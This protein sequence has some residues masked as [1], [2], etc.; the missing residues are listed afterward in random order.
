MRVIIHP[1]AQSC[2]C[3]FCTVPVACGGRMQYM[4]WYFER[5]SSCGPLYWHPWVCHSC[6]VVNPSLLLTRV[7]HRKHTI[8]YIHG[9]VC[10]YVL[11]SSILSLSFSLSLS[12]FSPPPPQVSMSR[13]DPDKYINYE[14]LAQNLKVI[15]D[16]YVYVSMSYIIPHLRSLVALARLYTTIHLFNVITTCVFHVHVCTLCKVPLH[17]LCI[18]CINTDTSHFQVATTF[19]LGRKDHLR[20]PGWP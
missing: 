19:D 20:S 3:H 8:K 12:L 2:M 4:Y 18:L 5:V 9:I 11:A 14:R 16:R 7:L 17:C 6:V 10:T 15:K 13:F 1:Q